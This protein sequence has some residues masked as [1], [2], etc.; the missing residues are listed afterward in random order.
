MI[1]KIGFIFICSVLV[2]LSGCNKNVTENEEFFYNPYTQKMIKYNDKSKKIELWNPAKNQFQYI[3]GNKN[4][5]V[6]GNSYTNDFDLIKLEK[7]SI[8]KIH[9]FH[10]N[11]GFFPIGE[12]NKKIYFIHSYY[13]ENGSED[14]KKRKLAIFDLENKELKEFLNTKGLIDYGVVG[15]NYIYYTVYDNEKDT[16][17]LMKIDNSETNQIPEVVKTE[18][19]DGLLLL[20]NNEL[21]YSDGNRLISDN[22]EYKKESVNFFYYD[23]L[24]QFYLNQESQL[25]IKV[26]NTINNTSFTEENIVGI[27]IEND[28]VMIC[29]IW[30]VITHDL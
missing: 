1:K 25:C 15:D 18:L 12:K 29:K 27:R 7:F 26:T 21:Y 28:K 19:N 6:N 3:I 30:E 23:S 5:F 4:I 14:Y 13:N 10:K 2:I 17:S 16:Y 8:T 24:F 11:E 9:E 20:A 22:K